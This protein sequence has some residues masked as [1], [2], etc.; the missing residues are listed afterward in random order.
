M[1]H[2]PLLL[3]REIEP[4]TSLLSFP[5][6]CGFPCAVFY[7]EKFDI[8][9]VRA[10]HLLQKNYSSAE[11]LFK[12]KAHWHCLLGSA[13]R[14]KHSCIVASTAMFALQL[15]AAFLL[16]KRN[17]ESRVRDVKYSPEEVSTPQ[18]S[19]PLI[20]TKLGRGLVMLEWGM[21]PICTSH[22]NHIPLE[23]L[24]IHLYQYC[25]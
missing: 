23:V 11:K 9:C 15:V 5:T 1:N 20:D 3:C 19:E 2:Y 22:V 14:I 10:E 12:L 13:Y 6:L 7:S 17:Q 18:V 24:K 8:H 25:K 4:F 21:G 16:L